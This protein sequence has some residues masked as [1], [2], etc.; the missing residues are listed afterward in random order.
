MSREKELYQSLASS[1][2]V[3]ITFIGI[4]H[5]F[6]GH[7]VFPWGP[8]TLGGVIGW[9]GLGIFIIVIGLLLLGGTLRIIRFPVIPWAIVASILG[10]IVSIFTA[11][12]HY[13]FHM[14]A[15]AVA[16]AAAAIVVFHRKASKLA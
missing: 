15:F 4:C 13:Q 16:L 1:G 3:L 12:V 14:F 9:H 2:A 7:I 5:E 6:V 8:A 10:L 11:I